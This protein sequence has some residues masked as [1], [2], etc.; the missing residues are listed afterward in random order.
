MN[1]GVGLLVVAEPPGCTGRQLALAVLCEV[2]QVPQCRR[3]VRRTLEQWDRAG[4]EEA[5]SLLVTELVTNVVLHARTDAVVRLSEVDGGVLL[6]VTDTSQ[7][8]P[9]LAAVS[10]STTGGRGL[11]LLDVYSTSRGLSVTAVGKTVWA[12]LAVS[13]TTPA[14]DEQALL[15]WQDLLELDGLELHDDPGP[16]SWA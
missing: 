7:V 5:G 3:F 14:T 16:T 15:G 11:R 1:S 13:V 8:L 12:V 2:S 6:E 9:R 10:T 4:A